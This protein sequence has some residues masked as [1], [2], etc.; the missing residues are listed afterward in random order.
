MREKSI[1]SF[2]SIS[3]KLVVPQ[4]ICDHSFIHLFRNIQWVPTMCWDWMWRR[5]GKRMRPT[6]FPIPC[7]S[8]SP[9]QSHW[10]SYNPSHL[11]AIRSPPRNPR[12]N[13]EPPAT[14]EICTIFKIQ[15]GTWHIMAKH[16]P[17]KPNVNKNFI[18]CIFNREGRESVFLHKQN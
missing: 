16:G 14:L 18:F 3:E 7:G 1:R 12:W 8:H 15:L 9:V 4:I 11:S 13:N 17:P 2:G 10:S 6:R 5:T